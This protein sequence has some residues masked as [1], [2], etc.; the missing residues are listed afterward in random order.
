MI[1]DTER[2][3][4]G[5]RGLPV[6][7]DGSKEPSQIDS[8]A[9][10]YA[11]NVT[12]R[13]GNGPRTR[14]GFH[15]IP[16]DYWINPV[17]QRTNS[18]LVGD[19]TL[20]TA[21]TSAS[22]GYSTGNW[23]T[24]SGA[25]TGYNGNYKITVTGL[26][27]FTFTNTTSGTA[28]A[29]GI[30]LRDE[31]NAYAQDIDESGTSKQRF[32]TFIKQGK[33]LQGVQ[34]YQDP[35]QNNPSQI[36]VVVDGWVL[37]LDFSERTC[38]RLNPQTRLNTELPVFMCQAERFIVIQNGIDEP[39]VFDGYSI[40]RASALNGASI[41][42][43]KQMVYGQG[44]LFVVVKE[45]SE[46]IAGDLVFGGST[47]NVGVTS[48]SAANPSE[49]TTDSAHGFT[50]GNLV[51]I[52]GHSSEPY[53]NSTYAVASTPTTT[54]FTITKAVTSPGRGGFV[55]R[56][57]AGQDSDCLRFTETNFLNEGGNLTV[58]NKYG[59]IVALAFL[60]VQ[61][62]ATGQGDLI[63]FCEYGAVTFQVSVPR[64]LWKN[65]PGFQRVLFDNIG[66]ANE[67]VLAVNGDL[68]FR[69]VQGNG[70]RTYRNARAEYASYGQ[71]SVS[72][73]VDPILQQD[74]E[75]LL[76]STSFA[77]FNNRLLMTCWPKQFPRRALSQV[78]AD[79]FAAEPVPVVF[80]GMTVLDFNS[81]STGRG[82]SAVVF[83][84]VWTGIQVVKLMQG[85]FDGQSR[86]FAFCLHEDDGI[87]S[88]EIWEVTE[89]A[90]Y[91]LHETAGSRLINAAII[92]KAFDF[93]DAMGQ[94]K[95]IRCD[96]WLDDIGGGPDN[97]FSCDLAY[98]PDNYPNFTKWDV[99]ERSFT[100]EFMLDDPALFGDYSVDFNEW[101]FS[102][103]K[104]FGSGSTAN[105]AISPDTFQTA[106]TLAAAGS[107]PA[108]I[109]RSF[110]ALAGRDYS[111]TVYAKYDNNQWIRLGLDFGGESYNAWFD[112]QNGT[113]GFVDEDAD[114]AIENVGN[115]W[116]KLT[117]T[118]FSDFEVQADTTIALAVDN[119]IIGG[120]VDENQ[121]VL[122]Y[123]PALERGLPGQ[124]T[125][126]FV[127]LERGYLAQVRFPTPSRA[128][129]LASGVP[130]YLGQ[131]FTLRVAWTG[132]ARLG[133]L[134]L[135]GHR[136]VEK[137]GGGI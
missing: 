81:V 68:F 31:D 66:S 60:Q 11:T 92:T 88:H 85:S 2:L 43:G 19:G 13:G 78:Q 44:R 54:T 25:S 52:R 61:D 73:E 41:P 65:T 122:L 1:A 30:S 121:E 16:V 47:T 10:W 36:L 96:L 104:A 8:G 87:R 126:K 115:G 33:Y 5:F 100:T 111:F 76:R 102:G 93:G 17:P 70:I 135:H 137:V 9:A 107:A 134:M 109:Y 7:M 37:A 86:C 120:N 21:T 67:N 34:F 99:F 80:S 38:K 82:K 108:K 18:S 56:F 72:A 50:V 35:L 24:V 62:T 116:Y 106:D 119:S 84:G 3:I 32:T 132:R 20:V 83:D 113:L 90:E 58:S 59:K 125:E 55:T 53:I 133:R 48:S 45:G 97:K 105:N 49:I 22:H 128:T 130:A 6:G 136:L 42:I 63:A 101:T 89:E 26:T 98:R 79:E 114:L 39:S 27:T 12:F 15:Q 29:P 51:T 4:D 23:V 110:N 77:L 57:N 124:E 127:N 69:S 131:D 129:N 28:A 74:T 103:M 64:E 118:A 75:W 95:L 91:D 94:K 123:G 112:V 71:T 46:I 117:L 40:Y 14:P